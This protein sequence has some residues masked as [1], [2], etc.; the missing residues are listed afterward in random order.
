MGHGSHLRGVIKTRARPLVELLYGFEVSGANTVAF[1]RKLAEEL[2]KDLLFGYHVHTS[3]LIHTTI[4]TSIQEHGKGGEPHKG[5]YEHKIIQKLIN[6][7]WF[8]KKK[9]SP[10]VRFTNVFSPFTDVGLA[11]CLTVVCCL[12]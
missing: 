9:L 6:L 8:G 4:L 11:P 2:K 1:N 10:G 5:L 12:C 7:V 3:Y